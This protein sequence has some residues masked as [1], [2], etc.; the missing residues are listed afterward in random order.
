M[1]TR[2][3]LRWLTN[4]DY[5][6]N[7]EMNRVQL[8]ASGAIM[9]WVSVHMLLTAAIAVL[10][11]MSLTISVLSWVVGEPLF[12]PA[13]DSLFTW[14]VSVW[15][16]SIVLRLE[17]VILGFASVVGAYSVIRPSW[18]REQLATKKG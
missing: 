13:P 3:Y 6:P 18:I 12:S 11:V 5:K 2:E 10:V 15:S 17:V 7:G 4:W 1:E 16:W 14:F 9:A 8:F